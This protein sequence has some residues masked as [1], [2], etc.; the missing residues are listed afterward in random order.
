MKKEKV[1]LEVNYIQEDKF[2][3]FKFESGKLTF[4]KDVIKGHH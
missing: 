2:A 4:L 1:G 3:S